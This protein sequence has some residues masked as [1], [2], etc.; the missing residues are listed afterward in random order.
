MQALEVMARLCSSEYRV[1]VC[2][3]SGEKGSLDD[4]VRALGGDVVPL[5]LDAKF[6]FRFVEFLRR[7]RYDVVHSQVL[8]ASGALLALAAAARVPVRIAHFHATRDL[9]RSTL[10]RRGQR[11]VMRALIDRFA[12]DIVACGVASMDAVWREGWRGD[13]RCRIIYNAVDV[14]RFERGPG[15]A[16]RVRAELGIVEGAPLYIH[17]GNETFEKNHS[18][19]LAIF[20]AILKID[21]RSYLVLAGTGTD[22]PD[23]TTAQAARAHG[24]ETRVLALG[25]RDDVPNLLSAADAL[26]LPSRAEG[27]PCV[28]LEAC[29]AGV[30]VLASDLPGVREVA[31]HLP[32]V[33]TLPLS[34]A[35]TAWA[36]AATALPAEAERIR[37]RQ[38][39]AHAFRTSVFHFGRAVEQHR[40][41][42]RRAELRGMQC[43]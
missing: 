1:D 33:R 5:R 31:A 2:A 27:L 4:R 19:L 16:G 21:P 38:T 12:T 36:Q 39:A 6:P 22:N 24:I 14:A 41:L 25:V 9:H 29:A 18:R 42:W 23:G 17:I 30:P 35:D 10:R 11:A 8:Y 20:S 15:A 13:G 26:L 40:A 7:E 28:V 43:S 32:L 37:L 3:L 34:A